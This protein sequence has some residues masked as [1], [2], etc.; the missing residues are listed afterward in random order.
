MWGISSDGRT[1]ALHA[2]GQGFDFPI[3]HHNPQPNGSRWIKCLGS[4]PMVN[5]STPNIWYGTALSRG[6]F[7][8]MTELAYV[9]ALEA[10]F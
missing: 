4:I 9:L 1:L 8:R 2:R 6:F 5:G 7:A 10:K 3:L